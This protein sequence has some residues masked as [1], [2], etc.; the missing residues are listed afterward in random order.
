VQGSLPNNHKQPEKIVQFS[1]SPGRPEPWPVQLSG[2]GWMTQ[3]GRGLFVPMSSRWVRPDRFAK[4]GR[5]IQAL[6]RDDPGGIPRRDSLV[7]GLVD[8]LVD[9]KMNPIRQA[10]GWCH[11]LCSRL[12]ECIQNR[13]HMG[14]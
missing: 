14:R 1:A 2:V 6:G 13:Y 9:E 12:V 11:E 4:S 8:E 5:M 10:D 3:M 7:D